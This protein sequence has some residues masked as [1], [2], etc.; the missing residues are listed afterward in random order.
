MNSLR[1]VDAEQGVV[2]GGVFCQI[3]H[4]FMD[5][6]VIQIM[7]NE[8]VFGYA[9]LTENV[10]N[11]FKSVVGRFH[12]A[13]GVVEKYEESMKSLL[14]EVISDHASAKKIIA[15]DIITGN[16]GGSTVD[17]NWNKALANHGVIEVLVA[18]AEGCQYQHMIV[19]FLEIALD[20]FLLLLWIRLGDMQCR[21]QMRIHEPI[22]NALID[23]Q[24]ELG[25]V[26][27]G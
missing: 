15:A 8:I 13:G 5:T 2:R 4:I 23:L 7:N 24:K 10:P 26:R 20:D 11:S 27:T 3:V 22:L 12:A 6:G 17:K 14:E 9:V 21:N 19:T 1:V 18:I 16:V 25:V